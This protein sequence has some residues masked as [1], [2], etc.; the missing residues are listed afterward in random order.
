M[1]RASLVSPEQSV[2]S[3]IIRSIDE[4]EPVCAGQGSVIAPPGTR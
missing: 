4:T 1:C 2:L 3:I